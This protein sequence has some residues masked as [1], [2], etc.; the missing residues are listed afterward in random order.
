MEESNCRLSME[1]ISGDGFPNLSLGILY[2]VY[3][4]QL[5]VWEMSLI[6]GESCLPKGWDSL[7]GR[8]EGCIFGLMIR[9]KLVLFMF[10]T[11]GYLGW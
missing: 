7:L 9:L 11:L 10:F 4:F 6:V 1:K 8:E 5:L 2:R 3:G